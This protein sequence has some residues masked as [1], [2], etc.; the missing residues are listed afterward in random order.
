MNKNCVIERP[1]V[2]ETQYKTTVTQRWVRMMRTNWEIMGRIIKD[3]SALG[4]YLLNMFY[5]GF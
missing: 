4:S 2:L 3:C 1:Y 5:L